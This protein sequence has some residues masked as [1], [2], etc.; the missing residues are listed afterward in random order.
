MTVE[1]KVK[2]IACKI[3]RKPDI[4]FN[5]IATFKDLGADSLDI[6]Q[7]MVAVEE[8]YDIELP[9]DE[10]QEVKSLKDFLAFIERKVG[11]KK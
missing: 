5:S 8:A 7:I 9:E 2:E 1:E 10:M 4:D 3:L 6:V 11:A